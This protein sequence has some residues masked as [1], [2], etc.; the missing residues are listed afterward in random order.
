MPRNRKLTAK[1]E[2]MQAPEAAPPI[3]FNDKEDI[4]EIETQ[5]MG[6]DDIKTYFPDAKILKYSELAQFTDIEQLLPENKTFVFLLYE[7]SLNVGHWVCVCRYDDIISFFDPYGVYPDKQLKWVPKLLRVKL[8]QTRP[9]LTCLFDKTKLEVEYNDFKFQTERDDINTCGRHCIFR[10]KTLINK[11]LSL[12]EYQ[13]FMK[14]LKKQ[15]KMSFDQLV[16]D[17]ISKV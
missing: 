5:P 14:Q 2:D 17:F 10:I 16:A 1:V 15:F 6:D 3:M 12:D 11:N 7:T 9:L 4:K 13:R 8:N